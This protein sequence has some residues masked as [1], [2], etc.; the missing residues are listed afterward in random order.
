MVRSA[1]RAK[2]EQV[3]QGSWA[4]TRSLGG[5][6]VQGLP[7]TQPRVCWQLCGPGQEP[8]LMNVA[9]GV[10]TSRVSEVC[11]VWVL[12]PNSATLLF[13]PPPVLTSVLQ[14]K[15]LTHPKTVQTAQTPPLAVR[16]PEGQPLLHSPSKASTHFTWFPRTGVQQW[17]PLHS[18]TNG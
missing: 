14:E 1:P 6:E 2:A 18:V 3:L 17:R 12:N 8:D 9:T 10:S 11:R 5:A 4:G 7:T 15:A 16:I 13:L